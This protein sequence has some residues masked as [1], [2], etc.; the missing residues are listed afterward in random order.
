MNRHLLESLR[1]GPNVRYALSSDYGGIFAAEA[2]GRAD[3]PWDIKHIRNLLGQEH[4]IGMVATRA[5]KVCGFAVYVND[6]DRI[7]LIRLTVHPDY[8]FSGVGTALILKLKERLRPT[9]R[10]TITVLCPEDEGYSGAKFLASQGFI[11][12]GV[13]R[14]AFG[15]THSIDGIEFVYRYHFASEESTN[16]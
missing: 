1:V 16:G 3:D 4:I 5:M 11:A 14:G 12:T 15:P 13:R 8:R 7:D 2:K 10:H 6:F 9:H